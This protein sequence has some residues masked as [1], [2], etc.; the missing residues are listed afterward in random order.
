[1][2]N[3]SDNSKPF[4]PICGNPKENKGSHNIKVCPG[5]QK[6]LETENE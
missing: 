6:I 2:E 1:M 3:Y 5:C 4:C